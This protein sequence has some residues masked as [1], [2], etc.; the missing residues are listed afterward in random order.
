MNSIVTSKPERASFHATEAAKHRA[1]GRE[2]EAKANRISLLRLASFLGA[3]LLA[4]VGFSQ[5][6]LPLVGAGFA[7]LLG[8]VTAVIVHARVEAARREL[9]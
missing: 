7:V 2:L 9:E 3:A 5:G 1:Q 4:F 8:F 6:S